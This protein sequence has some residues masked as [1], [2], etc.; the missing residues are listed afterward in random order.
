M[1]YIVTAFLLTLATLPA[2][3]AQRFAYVDTEFILQKIPEYGQAQREIEQI[4]AQW[5]GEIEALLSD[6]DALQQAY[7]AERIL[8]TEEMQTERLQ[9]IENLRKQ[10]RDLQI[11]YF[12]PDGELFKK[13]AELVKPIQD[14]VYNAVREVA[15]KRNLD[16]VFD[17]NG[18]VTMLYANSDKDISNEVLEQLGY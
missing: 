8:L 5:Q 9:E 18:A 15:R 10:A 17:K 1:R 4:S 3:H 6:A 14:Q 12:G 7:N 11:K 16:F 13:R 2:A